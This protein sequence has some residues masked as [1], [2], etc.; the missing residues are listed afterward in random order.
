MAVAIESLPDT[1]ICSGI[2]NRHEIK[3]NK[4]IEL[5]SQ[6]PSPV[7]GVKQIALESNS[8][9]AIAKLTAIPT[10]EPDV[11]PL[12]ESAGSVPDIKTYQ[13]REVLLDPLPPY[14]VAMEAQYKKDLQNGYYVHPKYVRTANAPEG[15][16]IYNP[17]AWTEKTPDGRRVIKGIVRSEDPD[18]ISTLRS[19]DLNNTDTSIPDLEISLNG[20]E[21]IGREDGFFQPDGKNSPLSGDVE[22]A[23]QPDKKLRFRTEFY[24]LVKQEN[25]CYTIQLRG[26]GDWDN[27]D[28]RVFALPNGNEGVVIRLRK[29]TKEEVESPAGKKIEKIVV[30]SE[31]RYREIRPDEDLTEVL[32]EM[33]NNPAYKINGVWPDNQN[34]WG[35]GNQYYAMQ[36]E[37]GKIVIGAKGHVATYTGKIIER[38]ANGKERVEAKRRYVSGVFMFDPDTLQALDPDTGYGPEFQDKPCFKITITPE[39][40]EQVIPLDKRKPRSEGI[41]S[42]AFSGGSLFV[43][44]DNHNIVTDKENNPQD[45]MGLDT[46]EELIDVGGWADDAP[47]MAVFRNPFPSSTRLIRSIHEPLIIKSSDLPYQLKVL[48]GSYK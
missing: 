17:V 3:N 46:V 34:I 25:G 37:D 32:A 13:T 48:S 26:K 23:E 9:E 38:D 6:V 31:L 10:R 29:E 8:V 47:Y 2:F 22:I 42:C 33:R 4:K 20:F 44:K 7:A 43:E 12:I 18:G 27:K 30:K 5:K 28:E 19:Y 1:G 35:A 16:L 45:T 24:R 21:R 14:F 15:H 39:Q 36:R 41:R 40:I 11:I